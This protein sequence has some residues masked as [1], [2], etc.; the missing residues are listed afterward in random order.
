MKAITYEKYGPAN[1][2][3]IKDIDQPKVTKNQV[4]LRIIET[5][6]TPT[7]IASRT[8]NPFIIRFFSGLFRPKLILGSDFVAEVVQLGEDSSKFNV[9]DRVF[10]SSNLT[11]GAYSEF[12]TIPENGIISKLDES[13]QT[14]DVAGICDAAMT[15]L[16]FIRDKAK[17]KAGDKILINGASGAI[18]TYAIQLAKY[19]GAEV[20]AVCSSS[21][22]ELVK[23]LKAD[24]VIDYTK[25]DFTKKIS[26]YDV[27]FD[28]IGKSS[29]TQCRKALKANGKYLTTV[30]NLNIIFHMLLTNRF[31]KKKAIFD[32]TGLSQNLEKLEFLKKLVLSKKLKAVIDRKYKMEDVVNAHIYVEAGHKKGQVILTISD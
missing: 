8:A 23:S 12:I 22:S 18:G 28:A 20:T 32:A 17:L 1:V 10:G 14:E 2:L 19:F 15:A 26:T 9:G 29:F 5:V 6:V 3:S 24:H 13:I 11:F 21:N 30:P 7:D 31:T 16:T 25:E 4:L 27:I